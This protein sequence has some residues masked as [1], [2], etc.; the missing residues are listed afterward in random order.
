MYY[1]KVNGK[2]YLEILKDLILNNEE[3]PCC[4]YVY[5]N[6]Q[7]DFVYHLVKIDIVNK[8]LLSEARGEF[9]LFDF[10]NE[11][12]NQCFDLMKNCFSNLEQ[13]KIKSF[14]DIPDV[15]HIDEEKLSKFSLSFEVEEFKNIKLFKENFVNEGFSENGLLPFF[16]SQDKK[17]VYLTLVCDWRFHDGKLKHYKFEKSLVNKKWFIDF[18]NKGLESTLK[19]SIR[20]IDDIKYDYERKN[21]PK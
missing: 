5:E 10:E 1:K 14:A 16:C 21:K 4:P 11:D 19:N 17:Y 13:L 15:K 20:E 9:L 8:E 3:I 6:Y 18:F 12:L 7:G 2:K